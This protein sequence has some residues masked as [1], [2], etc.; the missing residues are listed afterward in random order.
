MLISA[1]LLD[2][3]KNHTLQILPSS[4]HSSKGHWE[5]WMALMFQ[6]TLLLQTRHA[7]A[8]ARVASHRISATTFDMHFCHILSG[9]KGISS[10][11][12]VFHDA[13]VHDLVIPP[14]KYY[15]ADVGYPICDALLVPFHGVQYHLWE[16]ESNG[17]Q[18]VMFMAS[19]SMP[20]LISWTGP[21]IIR[22]SIILGWPRSALPSFR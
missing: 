11:G 21:T 17:L 1:C 4:T 2:A 22:S 5:H 19:F 9:W 6:L 15:L 10:D 3:S 16:W 12:G 7:I 20:C 13:H 14:G 8:T 18:C